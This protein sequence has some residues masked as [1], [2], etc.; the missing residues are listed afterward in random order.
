MTPTQTLTRVA[1]LFTLSVVAGAGLIGGSLGRRLRAK[2]FR[3]S[4]STPTGSI[5]SMFMRGISRHLR[6]R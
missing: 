5:F 3:P 2:G 4:G 6:T 1:A